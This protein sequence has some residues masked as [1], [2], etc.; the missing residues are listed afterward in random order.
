MVGITTECSLDSG[1]RIRKGDEPVSRIRRELAQV[2]QENLFTEKILLCPD[3]ASGHSLL[4][5]YALDGGSWLNLRI[6]TVDSLTREAAE[7]ALIQKGLTMIPDGSGALI[8]EGIF[9]NLH[10]DLEYS[11][12]L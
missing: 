1:H 11:L 10:P 9:R 5:R 6:A 4:E 12:R 3:Y 8:L 7:P 2:C